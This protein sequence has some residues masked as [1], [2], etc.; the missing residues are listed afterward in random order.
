MSYNL[1]VFDVRCQ[2]NLEPGQPIKVAFKFLENVH[3]GING[4][5]LVLTNILLSISSDG[6]LHFDLF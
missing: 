6:Q 2:K 3:A 4:Y 1:Y 5:A